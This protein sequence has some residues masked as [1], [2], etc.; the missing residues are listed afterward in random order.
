MT[1]KSTRDEIFN[2]VDELLWFHFPDDQNRTQGPV[3][4]QHNYKRYFF[5][6]ARQSVGIVN[7]DVLSAHVKTHWNIQ[8]QSP[9]SRDEESDLAELL[10]AWGEWQFAILALSEG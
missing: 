9:L 3:W 7:Q 4:S 2:A 8:R 6:L 1:S 5:D 10:H